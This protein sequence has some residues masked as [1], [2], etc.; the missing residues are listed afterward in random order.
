[1]AVMKMVT[2]VIFLGINAVTNV[3][4]MVEFFVASRRAYLV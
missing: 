3:A 2:A 4:P 1:M